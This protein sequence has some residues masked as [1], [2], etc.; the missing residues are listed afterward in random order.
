MKWTVQDIAVQCGAVPSCLIAPG[1][2]VAVFH[3]GTPLERYRCIDHAGEI[4]D[5]HELEDARHALLERQGMRSG[6][7]PQA[8]PFESVTDFLKRRGNPVE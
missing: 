6:E 7:A 8:L 3:P 2:P 1:D 4:P 5:P